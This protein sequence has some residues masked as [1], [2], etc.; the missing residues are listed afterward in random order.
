M[1]QRVQNGEMMAT[2]S[3]IHP[4]SQGSDAALRT[5]QWSLQC[6]CSQGPDRRC[7]PARE[8]CREASVFH[9]RQAHA[10][11]LLFRSL[12]WGLCKTRTLL[13][14]EKPHAAKGHGPLPPCLLP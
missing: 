1:R 11:F 7:E 10:L 4:T 12:H 13:Q 14:K 8:G 5:L 9:M 3:A 2:L 6:A